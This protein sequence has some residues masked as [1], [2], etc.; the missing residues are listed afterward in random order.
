MSAEDKIQR[1]RE[2]IKKPVEPPE[3]AREPPKAAMGP[4][5]ANQKPKSLEGLS[6]M[7]ITLFEM[8]DRLTEEEISWLRMRRLPQIHRGTRMPNL[9]TM[10]NRR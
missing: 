7:D 1:L 8:D 10:K 4:V 6:I 9:K 3:E 2:L 5:D